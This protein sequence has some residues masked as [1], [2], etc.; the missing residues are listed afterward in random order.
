MTVRVE[1]GYILTVHGDVETA[2]DPAEAR[3]HAAELIAAADECERQQRETEATCER[4]GHDWGHWFNGYWPWRN[5]ARRCQR[6]CKFGHEQE[7]GWMPFAAKLHRSPFTGERLECCGPG[8]EWCDAESLAPKF[9]E[10][11]RR[12]AQ[13]LEEA[14][15]VP[16]AF[17]AVGIEL[18]RNDNAEVRW[19]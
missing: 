3:Q 14:G 4:E 9:A 1:N 7:P 2:Y 6:G 18:G 11:V 19:R 8:C 12:A 13:A 17:A 15:E 5:H 16:A 10:I